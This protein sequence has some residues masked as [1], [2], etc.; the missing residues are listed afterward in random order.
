ML[1]VAGLAA[2]SWQAVEELKNNYE[3]EQERPETL[4]KELPRGLSS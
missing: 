2:S 3:P 1:V 4:E